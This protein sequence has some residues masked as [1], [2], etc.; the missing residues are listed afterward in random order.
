[1][2]SLYKAYQK[3]LQKSTTVEEVVLDRRFI[4]IKTDHVRDIG[5]NRLIVGHTGPDGIGQRDIARLVGLQDARHAERG[6]RTEGERIEEVV[7]D[8]AI[9]HIHPLRPL[10]RAHI[11]HIV[12]DE[13]DEPP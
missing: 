6:I 10:R 5:V 12:L 13:E 2:K 9:N 7:I 1:M 3:V 4:Q 11:D 8:P